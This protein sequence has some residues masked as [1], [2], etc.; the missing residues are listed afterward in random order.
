MRLPSFELEKRLCHNFCIGIDEA[1]RGP[2]AGPVVAAAAWINPKVFKRDFEEKKLIR[3]SKTLSEKQ[4]EFIYEYICQS[5]DFII[6]LGE[7]SQNI[8]DRI[9]ILNAALL[10]MKIAVDEIENKAVEIFG[11]KRGRICLLIDGNKRIP[12]MKYQQR[13]FAGGDARVFS[14][15]AASICAK[16]HRDNLM[17]KYSAEHP[18]YGFERHKGYGTKMHMEALKKHGPCVIHRKSFGPVREV[19]SITPAPSLRRSSKY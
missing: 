6:G 18:D 7:V 4:R 10:A 5:D 14:I 13:L 12:K 8:I 19:L 3:D 9:N 11:N 16:V 1:G 15:A 17:K 2:L